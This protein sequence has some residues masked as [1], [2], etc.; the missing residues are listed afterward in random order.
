MPT[1]KQLYLTDR[2]QALQNSFI[3]ITPFSESLKLTKTIKHKIT[4]IV[5]PNLAQFDQA[6]RE[7]HKEEKGKRAQGASSNEPRP[8]SQAKQVKEEVEKEELG[9]NKPD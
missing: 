5:L 9:D 8:A 6:M 2:E 1:P 3:K 7:I 4:P